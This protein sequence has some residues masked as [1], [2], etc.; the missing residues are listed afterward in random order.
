MSPAVRI[1]ELG[2][3]EVH[4]RLAKPPIVEQMRKRLGAQFALADVLVTI[5]SAAQLPLAVVDVKSDDA[6]QSDKP[7]EL[8]HRRVV[9]AL[10][11]QRITGGEQV[12]GVDAGG[13]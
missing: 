13:Q 1:D 11:R 3:L 5:D 8:C 2:C 7:V 12:T 9:A 10:W 4:R 6:I